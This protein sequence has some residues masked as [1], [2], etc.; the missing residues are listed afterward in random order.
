MT[1]TSAIADRAAMDHA[2][3]GPEMEPSAAGPAA[4]MLD[5]REQ[6]QRLSDV[7]EPDEPGYQA[8]QWKKNLDK[9]A[10]YSSWAAL[11][12]NL[13]G[14][15]LILMKLGDKTKNFVEKTVNN[16]LNLSFMFYGASGMANGREKKN[17]FMVLGFL[18]EMIFPWFGK[19]KYTYLLRGLP[20]GLDQLWVATDPRLNHKYKDGLFPDFRTG[21]KEVSKMLGTLMKEF[22]KNPLGTMFT[23]ETQGHHAFLSSLGSAVASVGYILT[24]KEGIFGPLR[25]LSGPLFDWAM[26][27][28]KNSLQ[29]ISGGFFLLESVFDF[30]ARFFDGKYPRLACNMLSHACGR[31]ALELYKNS[32]SVATVKV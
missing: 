21:F 32:D 3:P 24:G 29:K 31:F 30:V 17:A 26:L 14:A 9:I 6:L 16:I 19:L 1:E 11:L 28:S 15:P 5:L 22:A 23:K 20:T 2:V 4:P 25:D 13:I 12:A 7:K 27:A 18:G 8:P 10:S